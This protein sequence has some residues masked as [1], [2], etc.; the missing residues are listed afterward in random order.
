M[1]ETTGI[2]KVKKRISP[3]IFKGDKGERPESTS[4][5]SKGLV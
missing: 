5:K 4:T 2:K 1:D 3:P